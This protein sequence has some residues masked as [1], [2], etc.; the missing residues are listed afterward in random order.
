M[1]NLT[2]IDDSFIKNNTNFI[3]LMIEIKAG[4]NSKTIEVPNRHHH[5]FYNPES[6]KDSTLLLM[7]A[8]DKGVDGGV[9]VVTINQDNYKYN[10]P[11]IQGAYIYLDAKTGSVKAIL[12]AKELTAKRTAAT[13]ALASHYLSCKD[14]ISLLVIGTG[15]LSRNLIKAH[16]SVRPIRNVFVYGRNFET[17]KAVCNDFKD[18]IF[19]ILPVKT[20]EEIAPMVDIISCATLSDVPLI[21]GDYIRDGQ[22]I[23]LVG[24]YKKTMREADDETIVNSDVYIDS[25]QSGLTESGDIAIPLEKGVLKESDIID[26]LFG[27]CKKDAFQRTSRKQ[28][29]LFKSVGH[30]IED[31]A[32]AK[33][34]Y[35]MYQNKK[36]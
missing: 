19:T 18:E 35:N 12:D 3:D 34:Y 4:F 17:A 21:K 11:S 13:S 24:A 16:T 31:L 32:A 29:T 36:S 8:W 1:N 23:D 27:L 9:K 33:Y 22:H 25:F 2:L 5:E 14:S 20:I 6:G 30:A 15:V 7:P 26:D 10:L 28:L